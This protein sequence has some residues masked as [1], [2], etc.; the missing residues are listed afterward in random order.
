MSG[1]LRNSINIGL[2]RGLR[3]SISG[4]VAPVALVLKN[5]VTQGSDQLITQSG[6]NLTGN[7]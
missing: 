1:K 7:V 3:Q 4:G 5:L 2:N 6:D